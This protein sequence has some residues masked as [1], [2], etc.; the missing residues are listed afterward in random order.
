M[1]AR[2]LNLLG[3]PAGPPLAALGLF[4]LLLGASGASLADAPRTARLAIAGGAFS[5]KELR[6]PAG[7][8]VKLLIRNDDSLPAEFESSDLA[9]EVVVPGHTQVTTYVGPLK[10]GRYRFFNDFDRAMQGEVVAED[11]SR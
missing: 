6:L 5:P 10:P 4:S 2:A 7:V 8:Q 9:R 3:T 1:G 11:R